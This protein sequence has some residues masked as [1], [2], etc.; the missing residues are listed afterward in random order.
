MVYF[1]LS[2]EIY[3]A[4]HLQQIKHFTISKKECKS[5][6]MWK[7]TWNLIGF[8]YSAV[9]FPI[10]WYLKICE[11]NQV[12]Q[13]WH[14]S[15]NRWLLFKNIF[16]I[17]VFFIIFNMHFSPRFFF[18]NFFF[19]NYFS[20][21]ERIWFFFLGQNSCRMCP[22]SF[23][24]AYNLA[25][26]VL[27]KHARVVRKL[28]CPLCRQ[29]ASTMTNLVQHFKRKHKRAKLDRSRV[30]WIEVRRS[31]LRNGRYYPTVTNSENVFP[32]RQQHRA[33]QRHN[34]D[35]DFDEDDLMP[36]SHLQQQHRASQR[37][38]ADDDY[39]DAN[40]IIS[41]STNVATAQKQ[42]WWCR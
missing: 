5:V 21:I 17:D 13:N 37:H 16:A 2:F 34:S 31:D 20:N 25:Q 1:L 19:S 30:R 28:I 9:F 6:N 12:T 38:N 10:L 7:N 26:H 11:L 39:D 33:S 40:A 41:S 32:R 27:K 23:A 4:S 18:L 22:E 8:T 42:R 36:L 35:N 29:T 3:F 15:I 24:R 14:Y